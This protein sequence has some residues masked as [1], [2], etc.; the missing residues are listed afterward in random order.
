MPKLTNINRNTN[1]YSSFICIFNAIEL[2]A[3]HIDKIS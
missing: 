1:K 2:I 3:K